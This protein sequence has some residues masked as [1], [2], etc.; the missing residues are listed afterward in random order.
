VGTLA[1]A[2]EALAYRDPGT[3]VVIA[4]A[5]SDAELERLIHL[6]IGGAVIVVL[7][8]KSSWNQVP[9][10]WHPAIDGGRSKVVVPL[11]RALPPGKTRLV[12]VSATDPFPPA[13]RRAVSHGFGRQ[14]ARVPG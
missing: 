13:W 5:P 2:L 12:R 14:H 9:G 4:A 3:L 7:F 6:D 11:A 8:E 1:H 10:E